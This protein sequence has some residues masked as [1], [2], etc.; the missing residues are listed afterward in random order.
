MTRRK[1]DSSQPQAVATPPAVDDDSVNLSRKVDELSY[2]VERQRNVINLLTQRLSFMMSMFGIEDRVLQ[3]DSLNA[4][5]QSGNEDK[6]DSDSSA[7]HVPADAVTA[8]R[9]RDAYRPS[10]SS[11][12]HNL[13]P[14]DSF[15]SAVMTAVYTEQHTLESR[16]KNFVVSGLPD[17]TDVDDKTAV[18][19]LCHTEMNI[20]P[21]IRSCRR[22][23]KRVVGKV[24]PVLVSVYTVD[25]ASSVISNAKRLRK[26]TDLLVKSQVFINPD[27]TKAQSAAAYE[28][29]CQR[30]K[31]LQDRMKQNARDDSA[32]LCPNTFTATSTGQTTMNSPSA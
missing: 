7:S 10:A 27:L 13:S 25:E 17:S 22:L 31:K 24:Q 16:A 20:R 26:S 3:N 2:E 30:R 32:N 18:E 19:Q 9:D 12:T 21:N 6:Q 29:R 1:G 4:L 23:G 8:D 5:V 14:K 15:R 28:L 11:T